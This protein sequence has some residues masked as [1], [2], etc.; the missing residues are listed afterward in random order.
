MKGASSEHI[1]RHTVGVEQAE[2]DQAISRM[3]VNLSRSCGRD[4]GF[5]SL[6][7]LDCTKLRLFSQELQSVLTRKSPPT[8]TFSV[9][10]V[11]WGGSGRTPNGDV[12]EKVS[13]GSKAVVFE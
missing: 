6:T 12:A 13:C 4:K 5:T 10:G 11:Q 8:H 1:A 7:R 3:P 2:S 9:S